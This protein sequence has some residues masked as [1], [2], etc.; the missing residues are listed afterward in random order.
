VLVHETWR[1][2]ERRGG[3]STQCC[4][5]ETRF[6]G[7][8]LGRIV[9]KLRDQSASADRFAKGY[10]DRELRLARPELDGAQWLELIVAQM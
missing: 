9:S 3:P 1:K 4:I 2:F 6:H 7:Q 5:P 10:S 8:D